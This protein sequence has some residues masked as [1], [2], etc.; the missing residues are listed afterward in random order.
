MS[1]R[2]KTQ[3]RKTGGLRAIAYFGF[4]AAGALLIF[5]IWTASHPASPSDAGATAN[6]QAPAEQIAGGTGAVPAYFP[7]AAAARPFPAVLPAVEFSR[8]PAIERAYAVAAEIPG[9]L[10]QQPCY[11]HC[12]RMGHRSLLD[13]YASEHAAGCDICL[14]EALYAGQM[15]QQGQNPA[16]IRQEVI[17]GEWRD[18]RL[19]GQGR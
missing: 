16:T 4:A 10:A 17:R 14:M 1:K 15:T 7:S 8:Y 6:R 13:C 2:G 18:V 11:C 3:K 12:D 5:M 9:V 19:D